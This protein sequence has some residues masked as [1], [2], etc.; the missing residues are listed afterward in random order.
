[1]H[2]CFLSIYAGGRQSFTAGSSA[3]LPGNCTK[4]LNACGQGQAAVSTV[5]LFSS[6]S[7]TDCILTSSHFFDLSLGM[8]SCWLGGA[9]PQLYVTEVRMEKHA[10]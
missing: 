1:M 9:G 4:P 3:G 8:V 5:G 10:L 6:Q 2:R 7:V